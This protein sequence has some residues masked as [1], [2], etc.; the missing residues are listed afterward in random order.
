M[1]KKKQYPLGYDM[2]ILFPV[3]KQNPASMK[4]K[5]NEK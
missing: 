5:Q 3:E 2:S 4:G 1:I